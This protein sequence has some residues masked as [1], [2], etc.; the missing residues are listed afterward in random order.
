M[1]VGADVT[2]NNLLQLRFLDAEETVGEVVRPL[3]L[4]AVLYKGGGMLVLV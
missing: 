2:T 3:L 1:R 4:Y